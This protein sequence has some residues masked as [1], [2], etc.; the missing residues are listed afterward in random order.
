MIVGNERMKPFG[1]IKLSVKTEIA[2]E[3]ILLMSGDFGEDEELIALEV[4]SYLAL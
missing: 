3:A 1:Q 2:F 4:H